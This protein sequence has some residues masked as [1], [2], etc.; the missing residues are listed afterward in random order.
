[1]QAIN[2]AHQRTRDYGE[3]LH[4]F[5][6]V[7]FMGTPHGG[8]DLAFWMTYAGRV[9][10]TASLGTRTNKGLVKVLRRDS[11]F[12]GALSERFAVQN[13]SQPIISF[14][15][16]EKFPLLNCRVC[17]TLYPLCSFHFKDIRLLSDR[18]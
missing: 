2:I 3:I 11:V 18:V 9:L 17:S 10:Q 5:A 13:A 7:T 14:Y 4:R 6:G 16:T 15:E 8:A 12:L 1:M